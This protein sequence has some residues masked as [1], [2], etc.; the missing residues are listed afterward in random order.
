MLMAMQTEKGQAPKWVPALPPVAGSVAAKN[1]AAQQM[2]TPG[3]TM[4][5][6]PAPSAAMVGQRMGPGI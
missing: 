3:M 2:G 5:G 4:A 1:L 6:V